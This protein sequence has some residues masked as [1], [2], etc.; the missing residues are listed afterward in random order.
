MSC[1]HALTQFVEMSVQYI[2]CD[3][4]TYPWFAEMLLANNLF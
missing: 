2:A 1:E 4:W 3:I